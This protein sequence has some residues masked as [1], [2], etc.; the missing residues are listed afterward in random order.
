MKPEHPTPLSEADRILAAIR[1]ARDLDNGI[2]YDLDLTLADRRVPALLLLPHAHAPVPGA[3]LLHGFGSRKERM[4]DTIGES[5][6]RRGV[7]ALSVDLP[8]HGAR[9]AVPAHLRGESIAPLLAAWKEAVEEST[10]ALAYL[11]GH[12]A[13]DAGRLGIVGYSLGSFLANIVAGSSRGVHAVVLAAS[14]DL[15]DGMPFAS[16]VRGVV[17]P[18]RAVR[19]LAGRP[20]LMINGRFDRAV[21]ADQ[22]ERLFASAGEPKTMR[23]YG[24]G[25]WPPASE[26]DFASDW[27]ATQLEERR[28]RRRA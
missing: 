16:L 21:T 13:I 15:P 14:G 22:A 25:H 20:L 19:Q 10:A 28:S 2:R 11:A 17:D 7:A 5:L 1:A 24:G 4:T 18:L 9:G 26:I 6:L 12:E 3:L 27:L 23:W 8:L